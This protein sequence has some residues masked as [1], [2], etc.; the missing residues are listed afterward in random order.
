MCELFGVSARK[1]IPVN[2]QLKE[3]FSHSVHHA[4]GWGMAVFY[5]NSVS[6][7]K[8]PVQANKS[9]YLRERLRQPIA[10]KNMI[11]HIRLATKGGM[12]Y[13][14]C[15]P[16]V[17]RDN[18]DRCWTLAHNGTIFDYPAHDPYVCRQE[19]STDS[20]RILYFLV[21][22]VDRRQTEL[23]RGL[24]KSERFHLLDGLVCDMAAGNKLNLLIYDG[25]L[26]YVHTN[27]AN[28]LYVSKREDALLFATVP[29]DGGDWRPHPFNTLCA[30]QD[31]QTVFTGTDHGKEYKDNDKDMRMIFA[32]YAGL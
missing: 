5:E 28:S 8:E 17:L 26:M 15:H 27:Y 24:T 10:V 32:D 31:G 20:E 2:D 22:Q 4:N 19:G 14:N 21:D 18:H 13:G 9:S 30:Y 7:E 16:F 23:G 29:L 11:A 25:E 3:F 6:L 12:E 1:R